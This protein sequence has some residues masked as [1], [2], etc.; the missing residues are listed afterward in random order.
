MAIH[1]DGTNIYGLKLIVDP[2]P[3]FSA[4]RDSLEK[5]GERSI[6]EPDHATTTTARTEQHLY[7]PYTK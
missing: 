1:M 5:S 2:C 7:D 3:Q 4:G 6:A